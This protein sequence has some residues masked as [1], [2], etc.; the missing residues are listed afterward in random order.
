VQSSYQFSIEIP[1]TVVAG[2]RRDCFASLA[3]SFQHAAMAKSGATKLSLFCHVSLENWYELRKDHAHRAD[4]LSLSH[5][6]PWS[7][8]GYDDRPWK[9]FS[10]RTT[11]SFL[12]MLLERSRSNAR[13][14]GAP[15]TVSGPSLLVET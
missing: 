7:A 13:L 8:R 6:C 2:L 15:L 10:K 14:T 3:M 4:R 9:V 11:L 5:L 12:M 1:H